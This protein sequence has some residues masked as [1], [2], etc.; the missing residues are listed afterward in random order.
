MQITEEWVLSHAPSPSV[1]KNG[2]M[3]SR[4]GRFTE[5]KRTADGKT[6]WAGSAVNRY[7]VSL[8]CS[9]SEKEPLYTCSCPSSH[10]PCK[11]TVGLMYEI[12]EGKEFETGTI[13]AYVARVRVRHAAERAKSEA[14]LAR[15][16]GYDAAVKG[17]KMER[18]LDC[19]SKTEKL[20]NDL[21]ANGIVSISDLSAQTL[22]RLAAECGNC[23]LNGVRDML[24][25]VAVLERRSR[26][27]GEDTLR[28]YAAVA[29][30]LSALQSMIR[31]ARDFL[32]EQLSSASYAMEKPILFEALGGEWNLDELRELGSLR[33]HARL[34]QLSYD[35]RYDEARRCTV[36]R[37]FWLE[38]TRG[39]VVQTLER[40]A[41][42]PGRYAAAG[43]SCFEMLEVP[44]LY[45]AP[46]SSCH[47]V[48]WEKTTSVP[49][50]EEDIAAILQTAYPALDGALQFAREQLREPLL[51]DIV[52]VLLRI[53][54]FGSVRGEPV[55]LDTAGTC[56]VLRDRLS[57]GSDHASVRRLLECSA[58]SGEGGALFGLLFYEETLLCLQPYA[59]VTEREI[60]RLQF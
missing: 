49:V 26:Q 12:L 34:V 19:L 3:L 41:G 52:P 15:A 48:W 17:K 38:L 11:H 10:F 57:D 14:R 59:L 42:K 60:V 51:P 18:Q 54:S 5:R 36:E 40:R 13:P 55:L 47:R 32:G 1:A 7:H 33:K 44:L 21:A 6:W 16:R 23:A 30:E 4:A 8:D 22:D 9:V 46:Y 45:E 25:R 28:C 2:Q 20:I 56:V 39:D 31:R 27:E 24:E 37:G 29:Q 58:R 53:G 35:V 43:D 50:T